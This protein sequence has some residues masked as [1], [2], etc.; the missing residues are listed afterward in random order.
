MKSKVVAEI[1]LFT[2]Y[3]RYI[4][5]R[6]RGFERD[7]GGIMK[8]SSVLIGFMLVIVAGSAAGYHKCC[9]VHPQY[10]RKGSLQDLTCRLRG[11]FE[12]CK[13]NYEI[14]SSDGR[15]TCRIRLDKIEAV[16]TRL[17]LN[18]CSCA[19]DTPIEDEM[20]QKLLTSKKA[21]HKTVGLIL[22]DFKYHD[23]TV[24][25]QQVRASLGLDQK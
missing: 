12:D 18:Q 2:L 3:Y 1:L 20:I 17:F 23:K 8:K 4:E 16:Q 25:L 15:R 7:N 14:C 24:T 11:H 6:K 19:L 9:Y 13:H 5:G 10:G 22:R 21:Y